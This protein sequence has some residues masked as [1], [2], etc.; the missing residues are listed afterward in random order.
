[1]DTGFYRCLPNCF[2]EKSY[3][4]PSLGLLE[5]LDLV[6]IWAYF[7]RFMHKASTDGI[8]PGIILNYKVIWIFFHKFQKS[9][10]ATKSYLS[11]SEDEIVSNVTCMYQTIYVCVF[12]CIS[13]GLRGQNKKF[14]IHRYGFKFGYGAG[15][16]IHLS[17]VNEFYVPSHGFVGSSNLFFFNEISWSEINKKIAAL[18]AYKLQQ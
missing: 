4:L 11:E 13:Q 10:M 8:K 2:Q 16:G 7:L 3:F 17:S 15:T 6:Y 9:T 14:R 12:V 5:M 1:M 18:H